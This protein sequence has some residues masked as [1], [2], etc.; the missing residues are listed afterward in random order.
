MVH[1]S[2]FCLSCEALMLHAGQT[3]CGEDGCRVVA[4]PWHL[5]GADIPLRD[6]PMVPYA[7]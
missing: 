6:A 7:V 3:V 1:Y 4:G 5:R 2:T